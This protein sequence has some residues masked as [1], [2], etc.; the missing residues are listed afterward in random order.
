MNLVPNDFEPPK[1]PNTKIWRYMNFTKFV[2]M[3]ESGSLYFSRADRL[4][5]AFEGSWSKPFPLSDILLSPTE[6]K[7]YGVA[8]GRALFKLLRE[9]VF[10]SCWHINEYESMAM[11]SV[12]GGSNDAVAVQSTYSLLRESLPPAFHLGVVRYTLGSQAD[13][14]ISK[15]EDAKDLEH[16]MSV[17]SKMHPSLDPDSLQE[18]FLDQRFQKM[19]LGIFLR[20]RRA[21][22]HERELRA[23]VFLLNLLDYPASIGSYVRYEQ[24]DP[25]PHPYTLGIPQ[26]VELSQLVE[27]IYISPRA[28]TWFYDLVKKVTTRYGL[29][30]PV[31]PTSLDAEPIF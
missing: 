20:K 29:D 6:D 26:P 9:Y 30:V 13:E 10:A 18:P 19:L 11:W 31:D 3:L 8:L 5:D 2:D 7:R 4:G 28:H 27:R 24:G 21:F 1:D 16:V 12:Y 17:I 23:V 25:L 14:S 15:S 22:E